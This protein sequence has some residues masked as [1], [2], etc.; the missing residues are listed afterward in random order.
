M[1]EG[2]ARRPVQLEAP[3]DAVGE[4][5]D[6]QEAADREAAYRDDQRRPQD[7]QLPVAPE[8]AQLL[9]SRRRRPVA[10]ARRRVPRITAR[11]RR[12]IERRVELVLVHLEPA[13]QRP[14]GAATPGPPLLT[15]DD[16]GCLAVHV[17]TLTQVLVDDGPRL[18]R[19][20]GLHTGAADPQVALQ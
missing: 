18:Q 6:T 3:A 14:A 12:A 15:F 11:H 17:R 20:T 7:L 2:H 10:A 1:R 8:R 5:R 16:A 19:I 4:A 9:L 13:P